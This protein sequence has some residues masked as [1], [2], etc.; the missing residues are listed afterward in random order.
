MHGTL[1]NRFSVGDYER[2]RQAIWDTY[3]DSSAEAIARRDQ[4][5]AKLFYRSGWTQEELAQ[6]EGK[7]QR[8]IGRLL[9]FGRFL[10]F[11]PTGLNPKSD[12]F[13]PPANLTERRFRS[14]WERGDKSEG[15]ERIRFQAVI[16]LMRREATFMRERRPKIG[17]ALVDR[18]GDGKWHGLATMAKALA[19]EEEHVAATLHTM[20]ALRGTYGA[21]CERKRVGAGWH[22]RI[23]RNTRTISSDELSAK[24]G[25]LIELL[26]VEGKKNVVTISVGA[27]ARIAT[28]LRRQ[29]DA[30]TAV[31]GPA[32]N[33][34]A[35]D[36]EAIPASDKRE[37]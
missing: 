25:P 2:E 15:N 32:S 34:A 18:F 19:T 23:F 3:G 31:A 11:S 14:F 29:L 24:L 12:L 30:W 33:D 28:L 35:A 27:V 37:Q 9:C 1:P 22:Y 21:N 10:N 16:D 6:K 13:A 8:H 7:S 26:E 20:G 17:P 5:L 4:A 36:G